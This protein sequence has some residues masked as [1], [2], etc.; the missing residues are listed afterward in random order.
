MAPMDGITDAAFR[1][2]VCKYSKPSFVMTEFVNVEG[3]ARGAWKMLKSFFYGE[4][5]RPIIAQIYGVEVESFYKAAVMLCSLGFDGIDINMGCPVNKVA[6]RGSG[7]GL[8]QTPDLARKIIRSVQKGCKDWS[9]GISLEEAGVHSDIIERIDKF[10]EKG[11]FG[12][13]EA[14]RDLV[15]VSVKTRI[16]YSQDT[17]VE[18]AKELLE[19]EPACLIMHGR[20]L[21]QMYMG[22][23]NWESLAAVAKIC[24]EQS[25][26]FIGNGDVKSIKDAKKRIKKFGVDGVLVGR[27]M[28]GN[29]WFFDGVGDDEITYEMRRDIAL[30]HSEYFIEILGEFLPYAHIKKHLAYYIRSFDGAR[31]IRKKLMLVENLDEARVVLG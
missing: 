14:S 12:E 24:A 29:P 16:G 3:L 7:A 8:I 17:A 27:G 20:T 13:R 15:P 5:E 31:E 25:I 9:E 19:T 28:L 18:W 22:E 4:R 23:A 6:K 30:E 26:P 11:L 1:H 10:R 2:I 21:K